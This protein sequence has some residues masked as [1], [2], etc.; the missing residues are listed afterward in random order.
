MK[1]LLV[2]GKYLAAT[3]VIAIVSLMLLEFTFLLSM[4]IL[5]YFGPGAFA[6]FWTTLSILLITVVIRV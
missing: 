2:A 6:F 1:K 3:V 5:F 4:Y